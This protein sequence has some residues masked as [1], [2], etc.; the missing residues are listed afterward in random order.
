MFDCMLTTTY[1]APLDRVQTLLQTQHVNSKISA[2]WRYKGIYDCFTKVNRDQG[3]LSLWRGNLTSCI[4]IVPLTLLMLAMKK[5]Y[6]KTE[7][8][9]TSNNPLKLLF[10]EILLPG[11]LATSIWPLLYPMV[12]V[13]TRLQADVGI[14]PIRREFRG[15]R[16]CV[17]KI[18]QVEGIRSFYKGL[19]MSLSNALVHTILVPGI[20]NG[21]IILMLINGKQ[22]GELFQ[23]C[24][25]SSLIF[26]SHIVAY[27]LETMSKRIMIQQGK[28]HKLF[29]SGFE[30]YKWTMKNEGY[31]GFYRGFLPYLMLQCNPA[32]LGMLVGI[33]EYIQ[34]QRL[35]KE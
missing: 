29:N 22:P 19:S 33:Q 34:K 26:F 2:Q 5:V 3:T 9:L 27:P 32:I 28:S 6:N 35:E 25:G 4:T 16:D 20:F 15:F 12:F 18:Y 24:F 17:K 30:C 14:N 13:A 31:R 7:D 10:K 1:V 8:K 23:I 11:V 21:G